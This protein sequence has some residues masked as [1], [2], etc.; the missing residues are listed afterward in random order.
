MRC[1]HSTRLSGEYFSTCYFVSLCDWLVE[2]VYEKIHTVHQLFISPF[3]SVCW[4][5]EEKIKQK[6][7]LRG[8][9][10]LAHEFAPPQ[11]ERSSYKAKFSRLRWRWGPMQVAVFKRDTPPHQS[12]TSSF[13][14]LKVNRM[15]FGAGNWKL[16]TKM[17]FEKHF[18]NILETHGFRRII[19]E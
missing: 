19:E 1:N 9:V 3:P 7:V 15:Y 14:H 17:E 5:W 10:E 6:G 16:W 4:L 18:R 8:M 11:R 12:P 13:S 2:N